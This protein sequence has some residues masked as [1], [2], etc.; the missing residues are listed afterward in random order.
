M[1]TTPVPLGRTVALAQQTLTE[2]LRK[3]LAARN[4]APETWYALQV[5]ATRGPGIPREALCR[6]L[7]RPGTLTA[8]SIRELLARL[9]DEGLISGDT[10]IDLTTEGEARYQSL[11]EY[12]A[13]P[14]AQLLS[15]FDADDV[16]ITLRTLHAITERAAAE[17]VAAG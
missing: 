3:H 9:N 7:E 17:L 14:A 16:A 5:V 8:D 1:T 13:R 15:H 2:V 11:R 12:V 6:E 4:T 10:A